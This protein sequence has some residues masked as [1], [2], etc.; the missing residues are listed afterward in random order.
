MSW[1]SEIPWLLMSGGWDMTIRIWDIRQGECINVIY[2]HHADVYGLISHPQRPFIYVTCS[3]DTTIRFWS[4]HQT[5]YPIIV[6]YIIKN[7]VDKSTHEC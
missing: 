1:N 2:D 7:V 6:I 3:R 5:I 4:L